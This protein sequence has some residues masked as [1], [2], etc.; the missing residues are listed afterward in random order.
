MS[1]RCDTEM[2]H[3][4]LCSVSRALFSVTDSVHISLKSALACGLFNGTAPLLAF[5]E[6]I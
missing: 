3:G 2:A 6:H 1:R 4:L 5:A